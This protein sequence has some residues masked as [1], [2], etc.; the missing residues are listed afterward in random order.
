MILVFLGSSGKFL[1]NGSHFSQ[2]SPKNCNLDISGGF[3]I[4]IWV[5]LG[6]PENFSTSIPI[7]STLRVP[8]GFS[9]G[10]CYM[11]LQVGTS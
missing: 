9:F 10:C 6:L 7:T 3:K 1:E 2:N 11:S 8:P 5:F 4:K